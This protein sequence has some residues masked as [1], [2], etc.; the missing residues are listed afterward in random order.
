MNTPISI[1]YED[2]NGVRHKLKRIV[3]E[4]SE[5]RFFREAQGIVLKEI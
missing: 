3:Y 1:I 2:K 5:L 4:G